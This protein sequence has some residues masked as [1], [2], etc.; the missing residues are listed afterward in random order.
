MESQQLPPH[1]PP[2]QQ[3][4]QQGPQQQPQ[5]Q[6]DTQQNADDQCSSDNAATPGGNSD[7]V[8]DNGVVWLKVD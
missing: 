4:L 5:K 2:Q 1:Q 6:T 8:R 7:G 3:Q